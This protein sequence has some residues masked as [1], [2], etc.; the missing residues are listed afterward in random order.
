[1][2]RY[3]K[4]KSGKAEHRE[5]FT[6]CFGKIKSGWVIHHLDENPRNNAP[7]NLV[8]LPE[9]VHNL[10]HSFQNKHG[11]RLSREE[12]VRFTNGANPRKL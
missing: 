12:V 3:R 4:T 7:E 10:L 2:G 11:R 9:R 8:Q 1:M 6:A 5:V